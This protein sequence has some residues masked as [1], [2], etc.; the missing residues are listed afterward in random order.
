[1]K[2]RL[3]VNS[4]SIELGHKTVLDQVSLE[5]KQGQIACLIGESGCGKTTLLR[6]IA[7]FYQ[8]FSGTVVIDGDCVADAGQ[9]RAVD[10]RGIGM[11]FQ[12]LALYPHLSSRAN[13]AFGLGKI[14]QQERNQRIDELA[15]LLAI[16]PY[17]DKY[18]HELSGG[19]QQRIAIARALAPN[20]RLLLLDE[21]FSS[22]DAGLR[23][24]LALDIREVLKQEETTAIF[25]SHDQEEAFAIA[26]VV[27]VLREGRML[28]W[29]SPFDIYHRPLTRDVAAF[30]GEGVFIAAEVVDTHRVRT[31]LGEVRSQKE[32]GLQAGQT[33]QLLIRPDDI[34]HDDNSP[35]KV[36]IVDKVFRGAQFLY[37]LSTHDGT[38]IQS[39][40]P[41]HH[42][43]SI[44]EQMGILIEIDHLV[45]FAE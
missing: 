22:L 39:L 45:L 10:Q 27:G 8:P 16:E 3:E 26:D 12:D 38:C 5:M 20:P 6:T 42:N 44:Q 23:T 13:I 17:L 43:H 11:V 41:S 36:T 28:Q 33:A 29:A 9:S 30:I 2:Q 35:E 14:S 21:P 34:I 15:R 25:V 32:H 19:Q 1:M 40:V 31:S 4:V 7:G 24:R 18:P 37:T